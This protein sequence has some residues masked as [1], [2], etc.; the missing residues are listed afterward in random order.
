[1]L[2]NRNF[3]KNNQDLNMYLYICK[4]IL[5]LTLNY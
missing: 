2:E 4:F 3:W 5:Q 1:M